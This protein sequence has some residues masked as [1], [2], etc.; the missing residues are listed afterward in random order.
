MAKTDKNSILKTGMA[1]IGEAA[2]FAKARL[3]RRVVAGIGAGVLLLGAVIALAVVRPDIKMVDVVNQKV[4]TAPT[5]DELKAAVAKNPKNADLELD[6][7]HA[8]FDS[9]KKETA[10]AAYDKALGLDPKL[11]SDRVDSNLVSCFGTACQMAAYNVIVKRKVTGTEAGLRKLVAD[12]RYVVRTNAVAALEKL[13]KAQRGDWMTLW[14]VDTREESCDIRRN[15]VEKLGDF[16]DKSALAAIKA[17]NKKDDEETPW[18]KL[19]C[20]R[21]RPEDAEKKIL[22]RR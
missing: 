18:Y 11:E 4:G 3:S 5:L 6:L 17:A 21:S 16:G 7:A 10:L 9:G 19:S 20:L 14:I 1:K 22:A 8:A 12:K 15:A 2:T 13:G